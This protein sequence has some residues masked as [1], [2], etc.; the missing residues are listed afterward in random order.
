MKQSKQPLFALYYLTESYSNLASFIGK[1]KSQCILQVSSK[2]H[3]LTFISYNTDLYA[4]YPVLLLVFCKILFQVVFI[5][6]PYVT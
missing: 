2:V 3:L 4:L 6:V 5:K 1:P